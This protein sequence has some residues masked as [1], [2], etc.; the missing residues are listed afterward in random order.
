MNIFEKMEEVIEKHQCRKCEKCPCHWFDGFYSEQGCCI[1]EGR[2]CKIL[3]KFFKKSFLL[4]NF[5]GC[6]IPLPIIKLVCKVEDWQIK[7][8]YKKEQFGA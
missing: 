1:D 7:R 5:S 3:L 8:K 4:N 2:A 6:F